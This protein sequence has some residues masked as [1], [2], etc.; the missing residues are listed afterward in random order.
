MARSGATVNKWI[1]DEVE[2]LVIEARRSGL[3]LQQ[4]LAVVR[5]SWARTSRRAGCSKEEP[6]A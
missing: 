5:E 4:V 3:T 6:S 1:S 2:R